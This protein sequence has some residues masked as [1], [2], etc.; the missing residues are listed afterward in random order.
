MI[1]EIDV[2]PGDVSINRRLVPQ[3]DRKG[4]P[5]GRLV[6]NRHY[7]SELERMGLI[8]R[9]AC[10]RAGWRTTKRRVSVHVFTRW[11]GPLGDCDATAKAVVDSLQIGGVVANDKQCRPITLDCCWSSK[12]RGITVTVEEV[13]DA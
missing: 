10:L 11:G 5:T 4:R 6:K 7:R 3:H 8:V 2:D 1:I 13:L 12:Q 9:Q